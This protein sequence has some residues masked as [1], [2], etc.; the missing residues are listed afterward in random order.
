MP[1][2][3][4]Q[5]SLP[6]KDVEA[7][8]LLGRRLGKL[9]QPGDVMLLHGD[10]G[11]GKTT[12]TQ[13]IAVGLDVPADQYVTSPSFALL[14]EYPGRVALFHIDCYRLSGE[15]DVEGAG[16]VDYIGSPG[17]T[18]IEWP[19]RLGSFTP[20]ERLDL[21]LRAINENERIC[22]LEP[23]GSSWTTRIDKMVAGFKMQVR[24]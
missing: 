23:H 11:A 20:T 14:H 24:L 15:D 16:L 1:T 21:T 4:P 7:T 6:L 22:I 18:V 5:Y 10:L 12:L 3:Q 13:A 8:A 17:L 19:D 9:A 2:E